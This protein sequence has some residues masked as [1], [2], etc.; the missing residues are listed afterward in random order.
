M[1]YQETLCGYPAGYH[2]IICSFCTTMKL[3]FV[4]N[5]NNK[6]KLPWNLI[7][8]SLPLRMSYS[9][10]HFICTLCFVLSKC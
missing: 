7:R 3:L 5:L 6:D 2:M 4:Q 1:D 9:L 8:Y 10:I